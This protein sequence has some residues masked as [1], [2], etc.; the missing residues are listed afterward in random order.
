MDSDL[1]KRIQSTSLTK[2]QEKIARYFLKNQS[3]ICSL[4]SMEA[5]KEIGVSDASI[6]RFARAIGYEGFADL[7]ADYYQSLVESAYSRMSLTERMHQSTERYSSEELSMQYLELMQNN[8][9]GTFHSNEPEKYQQCTDLLISGKKRYVIG[10]RGCRG[11]AAQFSRL[12][13]F[14][15]PNVHCLLDGECVSINDLQDIGEG[16]VAIMFAF[17]RYYKMDVEYLKLAQKQGAKICLVTDELVSPLVGYASVVLQAQT[18]HMSFFNSSLGAI[19]I[20]EYL[21]TLISREVDFRERIQNR[22]RI[23]EYQRLQ[24]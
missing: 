1:L 21:L 10:L 9:F 6:I 14:M 13:G 24:L 8:I 11:V 20:A 22:D 3:R 18:E 5:A 17:A 23:T 4:S 19:L 2:A 15:L 12:L 16:D 7:K